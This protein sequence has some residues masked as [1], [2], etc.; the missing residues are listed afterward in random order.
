MPAEA[1]T[2]AFPEWCVERW[3]P[4]RPLQAW[5]AGVVEAAQ[6]PLGQPA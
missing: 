6:A 4:L 5:V 2:E 3:R 1:L